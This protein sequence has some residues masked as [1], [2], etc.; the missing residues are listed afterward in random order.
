[1]TDER[2]DTACT[3]IVDMYFSAEE[4]RC[5]ESMTPEILSNKSLF[6]RHIRC[7]IF[8][9]FITLKFKGD[10]NKIE[11]WIDKFWIKC[12]TGAEIKEDEEEVE[13]KIV[14]ARYN[15]VEGF[16]IPKGVDLEDKTQ[17]KDYGVKWNKL[18][19][20][21]NNEDEE[22]I[23]IESE[24]WIHSFDSRYPDKVDIESADD[25]GVD[26]DDESEEEEDE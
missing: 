20:T 12:T 14:L 8:Y 22:E 17:V 4:R 10:Y 24:G 3:K 5:V 25:W 13:R 6:I 11:K 16:R 19:I 26:Y 15:V 7:H 18:F 9:S 23:E 2:M 21:M 1:M